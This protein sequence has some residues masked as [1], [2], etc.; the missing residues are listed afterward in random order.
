VNPWY[1]SFGLRGGVKGRVEWGS[2]RLS[3]DYLL[4]G[5]IQSPPRHRGTE[6]QV[7]ENGMT[8]RCLSSV[9]VLSA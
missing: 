3:K 4:V 8:L 5:G 1:S 7:E 2:H 9:A 6:N